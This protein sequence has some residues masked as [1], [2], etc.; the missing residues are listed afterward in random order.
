[1][2]DVYRS[3]GYARRGGKGGADPRQPDPRAP[4]TSGPLPEDV[5][6]ALKEIAR[7]AERAATAAKEA[8]QAAEEKRRADI[9]AT[10][11]RCLTGGCNYHGVMGDGQCPVCKGFTLHDVS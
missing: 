9:D 2:G 4:K 7:S 3:A 10:P 5:V 6:K 8:A 11:A 1:M